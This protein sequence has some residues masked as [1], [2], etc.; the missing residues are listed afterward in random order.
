ME[1]GLPDRSHICG[2]MQPWPDLQGLRRKGVEEGIPCPLTPQTL[3]SPAGG[4]LWPK[5][6]GSQ[7]AKEPGDEVRSGQPPPQWSA[8]GAQ[9]TADNGP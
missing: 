3:M 7:G 4:P 5:P 6:V 1:E 8:S 2:G 9:G